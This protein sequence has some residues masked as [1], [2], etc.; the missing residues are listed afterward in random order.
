MKK[1]EIILAVLAVI[2]LGFNLNRVPGASALTVL[3]LSSLSVFY[4][5]LGFAL[6]NGV[7]LRAIFKKGS[8]T[9]I[10]KARTFGAVAAGLTLS[11]TL[12]G[13]MFKIQIWR[14]AD[15]Q[16]RTGLFGLAIVTAVGL[17]KYFKNKSPYY[18]RIFKRAA[19]IGGFGLILIL[20]PSTMWTEIRYRN[21]PEYVEAFKK[22]M[23]DPDNAALWKDVDNE[24]RKINNE[25]VAE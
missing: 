9:E 3:T 16:L 13:I 21:H 1:A 24:M 12:V 19:I 8:F 5:Y 23:A 20:S 2:A 11:V 10:S 22:A 14:G 17:V 7:R 4:M 6:F 18:T 15:L 25:Q